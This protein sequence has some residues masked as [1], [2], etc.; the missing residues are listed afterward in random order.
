MVVFYPLDTGK[1]V[2][3]EVIGPSVIHF[4]PFESKKVVQELLSDMYPETPSVELSTQ[5]AML[6]DDAVSILGYA[7]ARRAVVK[8][9]TGE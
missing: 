1:W 9:E 3:A 4:G 7:A 5:R 8:E 2:F 6:D